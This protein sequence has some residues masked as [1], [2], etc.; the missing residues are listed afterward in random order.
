M[1]GKISWF[2]FVCNSTP[3]KNVRTQKKNTFDRNWMLKNVIEL[4]VA[5]FK[6]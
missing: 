5:N 1:G 6:G 3:E 2:C 4:A